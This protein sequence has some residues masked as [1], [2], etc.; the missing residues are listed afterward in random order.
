[1]VLAAL[2]SN[3]APAR[4]PHHRSEPVEEFAGRSM[5]FGLQKGVRT[6]QGVKLDGLE[7]DMYPVIG[8]AREV[9]RAYRCDLVITSGL[10]GRHAKGSRHY[11]GRALDFRTRD[12]SRPART[13]VA[14]KL[15]EA[16]GGDFRVLLEKDH[17]HVEYIPSASPADS[18]VARSSRSK[19]RDEL[20]GAAKLA[21]ETPQIPS[22][23]QEAL[24]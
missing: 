1:M 22:I 8:A 23:Q 4:I 6:K 24:Q 16:L 21:E 12:L 15:R 2:L 17:V 14:R 18:R 3:L 19:R 10:D 13:R 7:P 11:V 9:W 5:A 20:H